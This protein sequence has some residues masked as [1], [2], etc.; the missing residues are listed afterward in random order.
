MTKDTKKTKSNTNSGSIAP[1]GDRVLIKENTTSKENKT[2]SG[3]IIPITVSDDKGSKNGEI[4]A[5]GPG[6][7]DDGVLVPMSVKAGDTVLF[8][9]GDKVVIDNVEYY[10]VKESEI[11]A[12]IK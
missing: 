2:A 4:I 5:V 9:W 12:I 8:Q 7:Y 10:I 1:L 6:R 11:L 3:I